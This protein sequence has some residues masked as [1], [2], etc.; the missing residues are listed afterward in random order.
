MF[1]TGRMANCW[2]GRSE[3]ARLS[4]VIIFLSFVFMLAFKKHCFL[5]P[6][7]DPAASNRGKCGA[8]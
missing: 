3:A 1:I 4:F 7:T 6:T 8:V 5:N 2:V